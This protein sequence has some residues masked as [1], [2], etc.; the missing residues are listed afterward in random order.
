MVADVAGIEPALVIEC[1]GNLL[2]ENN[3]WRRPGRATFRRPNTLPSLANSRPAASTIF[4]S[5]PNSG[6]PLF[7]ACA[8]SS[9][10]TGARQ[11]RPSAIRAFPSGLISVMP[12]ACTTSTAYFSSKHSMIRLGQAETPDQHAFKVRQH[13][14]RRFE[15][16]QKAEPGPWARRPQPSP[17]PNRGGS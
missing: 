11:L 9:L 15:I 17:F 1:V 3:R 13:F 4:I 16:L 2:R 8:R 14:S 12:H 6:P 10:H 7:S 5:T